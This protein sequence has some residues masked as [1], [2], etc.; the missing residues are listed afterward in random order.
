MSKIYESAVLLGDR[1]PDG[2]EIDYITEFHMTGD[3]RLFPPRPEWE[4]KG[5]RPDEYSRWLLGDWRPLEELWEELG[6]DPTR[7]DALST[8]LEVWLV[9][10]ETVPVERAVDAHFAGRPL[11]RPGDVARTDWRSRCA[12]RPYDTLPISRA[13]IPHGVILSRSGDAWIREA[14]VRDVALPFY[15]GIMIQPFV[16]SARGWLSG[17][18]LKAKWDYADHDHPV[19]NPQYLM[20]IGDLAVDGLTARHKIGFRDVSRDTDGRSFQ[21]AMLPDFPAGHSAPVLTTESNSVSS[22]VPILPWLLGI[23]NCFVFDWQTRQRGGAAHLTW[24][25]LKEMAL[26][27]TATVVGRVASLVMRLGL[28]SPVYA[29]LLVRTRTFEQA[30]VSGEFAVLDAEQY[31]LRAIIDAVAA[32]VYELDLSDMVHVLSEVDHPADRIESIK[33]TLDACGFWRVD[34]EKDP[35]LR[36]TVLT[37]VAAKDL[38]E[39]I[40]AAGGDRE[41][42]TA[43]FLSQNAGEGWMLPETLRLADY[44]LGH[45]DRAKEHQPVASRF[46]PRFYDW[47][48]AQSPEER[49]QE[50]HLH[51][52]NLLGAERYGELLATTIAD[53]ASDEDDFIPLLTGLSTNLD[54]DYRRRLLGEPG[55]AALIAQFCVRN[56]RRR[57][58]WR[59][60]LTTLTAADLLD[61][62]RR[63][64]V[65]D[66]LLKRKL[67]TA[68]LHEQLTTSRFTLP[69][70]SG[71]L[72]AAE[73]KHE[74]QLRSQR[75]PR[76]LF[77]D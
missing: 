13:G 4:A 58:S 25:M 18:G 46:G 39:K 3:S 37:L 73:P 48:L 42:G 24:G 11:L 68:E 47:Q 36:H 15:Q 54:D 77:D 21:G 51:A 23:L 17:T 10:P 57:K 62:L 32:T 14:D 44:G 22:G 75:A 38:R 53:D 5:Y 1:G 63:A 64:R 76:K 31:R 41:K 65:F 60:L 55:V 72:I 45:D 33:G 56:G 50:T 71:D 30:G 66:R 74:F 16:P 19:W 52:R 12:R 7:P 29:P 9:E 61:D 67:I 49:E 40:A 27:T 20:G 26:P 35:E 2:W 8:D 70:H 59:R 34:K 43:A 28:S 6:V 69:E